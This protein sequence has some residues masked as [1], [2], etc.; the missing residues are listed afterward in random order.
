MKK[1][2][3]TRQIVLAATSVLA[4]A[5]ACY[6]VTDYI[7]YHSVAL[8]L[9][10]AV[11]VLAMRL[12]L[13]AVIVAAVLSA[14]VWDFFFIPPYFTFT[15]GSED[16]LLIAMYFIVAVL[17]GVINHRVRQLERVQRQKAHSDSSLKL[18]NTLFNSLS[19][20]LR[21]PV[22]AILGAADTL[23]EN[24]RVLSEEQKRAAGRNCRRCAEAQR[25]GGK[26]AE[27]VAPQSGHDFG[28]KEWCDV[29][30]LLYSTLEK[31]NAEQRD[32]PV[33]ISLPDDLPLVRLDFG[34]TEQIVRNLLN[35][36]FRHTPAGTPVRITAKIE[37]DTAGHFVADDQSDPPLHLVR[38]NMTY[39][40][41]IEVSDRGPGFPLE[42]IERVFDKFYRPSNTAAG[43]TGLGLYVV[44]GFVE[45][46]G[47]E[48][49]LSN[50]SQGGARFT[51]EFPTPV[52]PQ[53]LHNQ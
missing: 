12:S 21:T 14:L 25:T 33:D 35:N 27:H 51:I 34:L 26:P 48:I 22:A 18:Y 52:M 15:I 46:Q 30:D 37:H 6:P 45:A 41:Q 9:L 32:H 36:A 13:P 42:E 3:T 5:A 19:H 31:L 28:Q 39:R 53:N 50:Q 43:G 7:G 16:V 20:E 4:V 1:V 44:K 8:V 24:E 23:Q 40:L 11:S 49:A 47:G 38:D 2:N 10:L 17:N 29:A